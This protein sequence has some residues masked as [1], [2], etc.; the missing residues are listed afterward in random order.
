MKSFS[1]ATSAV[2]LLALALFGSANARSL[3]QAAAAPAV[4]PIKA[5]QTTVNFAPIATSCG[6]PAKFGISC[7]G[8]NAIDATCHARMRGFCCTPAG[9]AADSKAFDGTRGPL[10]A[11]KQLTIISWPDPLS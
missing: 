10:Q 11:F 5:D 3:S 7:L 1:K 6:E 9:A 2:L 4:C 8:S